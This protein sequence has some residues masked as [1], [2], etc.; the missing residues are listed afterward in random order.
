[1]WLSHFSIPSPHFTPPKKRYLDEVTIASTDW[2]LLNQGKTDSSNIFLVIKSR[3]SEE[4][5]YDQ[6]EREYGC[7]FSERFRAHKAVIIAQGVL[8]Y[9]PKLIVFF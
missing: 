4:K 9:V 3:W 1:M 7:R 6:R 8:F 5:L 2:S